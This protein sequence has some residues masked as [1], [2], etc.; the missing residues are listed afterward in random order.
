[1]SG[2]DFRFPI[3]QE[4]SVSGGV[5]VTQGSRAVAGLKELPSG[6]KS[7]WRVPENLV[8][9]GTETFSRVVTGAGLLAPQ[10]LEMAAGVGA[11][12]EYFLDMDSSEDELNYRFQFLS[13][14][15]TGRMSIAAV[16]KDGR[17][18]ATVGYVFTGGMPEKN[19]RAVWIDR[20]LANNYQGGWVQSQIR[21]SELFSTQV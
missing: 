18:V 10:A 4:S 20:R 16:G 12:T 2:C 1:M 13:T 17:T 9:E 8:T 3:R 6:E 5:P 19:D 11:R 21:P 14:Q 15:G 7:D